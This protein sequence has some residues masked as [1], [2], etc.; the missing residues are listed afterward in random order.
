MLCSL[1]PLTSPLYEEPPDYCTAF[2]QWRE[3]RRIGYRQT[4][5]LL[6]IPASVISQME[7]GEIMVTAEAFEQHRLHA[8]TLSKNALLAIKRMLKGETVTYENSG[9]GKREWSELQAVLN[10]ES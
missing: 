2:R 7:R 9:L 6:G 1:Q 10:G 4:A 5:K 3:G 8:I